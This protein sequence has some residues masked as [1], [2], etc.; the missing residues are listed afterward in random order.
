[1]TADM[2]PVCVSN[3]HGRQRR[4]SRHIGLQR[5]VGA[6]CEIRTR[7]RVNANKL[8]PILGNNK[9]IF[10]EFEASERVDATGVALRFAPCLSRSVG[11]GTSLNY[12]RFSKKRKLPSPSPNT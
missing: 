6:F 12:K 3:E 11:I 1:M 9:V 10:R 4:Q 7:A 8:M 2:V 5:V